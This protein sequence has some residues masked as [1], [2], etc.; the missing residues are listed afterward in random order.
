M[1]AFVKGP[2]CVDRPPEPI[3]IDHRILS[4][5]EALRAPCARSIRH[6]PRSTQPRDWGME[7]APASNG[8]LLARKNLAIEVLAEAGAER[9]PLDELEG[10]SAVFEPVGPQEQG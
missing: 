6:D 9:L 7:R 1:I 5:R 2:E 3:G 4:S 8:C 10:P